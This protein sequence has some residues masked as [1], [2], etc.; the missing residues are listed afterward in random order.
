M[1]NKKEKINTEYILSR[2]INEQND[3][4]NGGFPPIFLCD[5]NNQIINEEEN[6]N[7]E[8]SSRKTSVSIKDILNERRD[9]TPFIIL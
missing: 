8:Y 3:F 4:P 2:I 7:R 1:N 5:K 9:T 6:K